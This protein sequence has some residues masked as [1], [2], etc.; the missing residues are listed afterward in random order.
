MY[1]GAQFS[2]SLFYLF[3]LSSFVSLIRLNSLCLLKV[4]S[5]KPSQRFRST[6]ALK[7]RYLNLIAI[8]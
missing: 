1:L 7:R 6:F 8:F 5:E 2:V 3:F 4:L